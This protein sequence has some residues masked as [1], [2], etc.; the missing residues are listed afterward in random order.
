MPSFSARERWFQDSLKMH[1][2]ESKTHQ[3]LRLFKSNSQPRPHI[4]TF[5]DP[6]NRGL[7]NRYLPLKKFC[8]EMNPHSSSNVVEGTAVYRQT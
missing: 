4:C 6:A 2:W 1:L 8:I 5:P 3:N 7:C